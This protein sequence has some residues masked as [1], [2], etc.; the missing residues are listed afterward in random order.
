MV[1]EAELTGGTLILLP[2]LIHCIG[3]SQG[4]RGGCNV[5]EKLLTHSAPSLH[6]CGNRLT[7]RKA[8][9]QGAQRG[10]GAKVSDPHPGASPREG[11]GGGGTTECSKEAF[12][13]SS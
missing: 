10:L 13:S 12:T 4:T 3:A 6:Q 1:T 11:E 5:F 7:E 9:V 2:N 8:L